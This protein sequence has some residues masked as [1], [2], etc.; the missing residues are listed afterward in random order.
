MQDT[1]FEDGKDP[2]AFRTIGEVSSALDIKPHVLRYWEEQFPM[3]RPVKRS[4]GRRYYRPGDIDLLQTIDRLL[5]EEGYT[6]R[7]AIKAIEDGAA[8]P[9][10][11]APP[12][13]PSPE[14]VA[15]LRG[16][17]E[18]LKA[19]GV[20]GSREPP[21]PERK[22]VLL[23]ARLRALREKLASALIE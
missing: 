11:P 8:K 6:I 20:D 19:S 2:Q 3:L 12:P 1:L 10:E 7:G 5:N 22:D 16:A 21:K 4:G 17:M 18:T 9:A 15:R 14:M 23:H 13:G